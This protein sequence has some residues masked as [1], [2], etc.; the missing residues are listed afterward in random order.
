MAPSVHIQL[1]GTFFVSV[2][3]VTVTTLEV[4]RVQSLLAYL[5]LHRTAS[6]ARLH[7][8]SLF[9]PESPDAQALTNLRTVLH[10]IRQSLP[11]AEAFL[12]IDRHS[13]QWR[14]EP[15]ASWVFDVL[16][17]EHARVGANR[18]EQKHD[19]QGMR[20]ALEQA[21]ERY[22][23]D[24]LP[25]CYD[26]WILPERD[27]LRQ[28]FL[29]ALE[30]LIDL[31][32]QERDYAAAIT[33]AQRMLRHD[34]LR[35]ETYRQ[36]MRLYAVCGDRAAALRVY[37][38]C[39]SA[40]ERELSVE[41]GSATRSVYERLLQSQESAEPLVENAARGGA[42][43]LVGRKQEWVQLQ[44][45]WRRASAGETHL[46]VLAGEAGIGKTCL[47]E[48]LL[49]WVSRQGRSVAA[50]RCYATEGELAY[51][52]V[53]AW[54]RS[55]ALRAAIRNLPAIWLTEIAR[56]VPEV[57]AE[58][59]DLEWPTPLLES[60]QRQRLFE[61]L[62]RA[63]LAGRQ[64]LLLFLDDMHWGDQGTLEW[65]H[66]LLRFDTQAP[67]LLVGTLRP[68]E[69]TAE[70]PLRSALLALQR[71]KQVTEIHLN[72]LDAAE[73][74]MLAEHVARRP[75]DPGGVATLYQETE[76]N[77]LFVVEAVR[78]GF[79]EQRAGDENL[80]GHG[81]MLTPT[82]QAVLG[83]RLAQ[84]SPQAQEVAGLASVIGRAFTFAVLAQASQKEEEA[85]VRALDELWQRRIVREHGADA[86]DFSH[87][88]LREA[89]YAALSA[90]RQ[91]FLH[92]HVAQALE[93]LYTDALEQ[94]SGQ[95]AVHF[96]R[97]G[98]PV[99]A[100]TYY[101]Q[102]G[103]LAQQTYANVEAITAFRRALSLLEM[104]PLAT[105]RQAWRQE[106]AAQLQEH[107]GDLL[108]ISSEYSA[109]RDCYQAA[110]SQ[111]PASIEQARLQGKIGNTWE[112]QRNNEAALH[113]YELAEQLLG[114]Q[115]V[116]EASQ[117]WQQWIEIQRNRLQVYYWLA[118]T[119]KMRALI[120]QTQPIVAKHGVPSQRAA[121]FQCLY[122]LTMRQHRYL[123]P[124]E[125]LG[126]AE[127]EL[128][129]AQEGGN[130][131]EVGWARLDLG[132]AYLGRDQLDQAEEHLQAALQ[133]GEH[134]GHLMLQ[135]ICLTF[136]TLV[137]R[138]R[139]QAETVKTLLSRAEAV[140]NKTQNTEF[141]GIVQ[142]NLAWLAWREG[143]LA[144]T[145]THGNKALELW[146]QTSVV[147]PM[148]WAALWPLLG[149][150]LA[151]QQLLDACMQ[152]HRL[153]APDQYHLPDDLAALLTAAIQAWDG[154][155]SEM[156]AHHLQQALPLAQER[157][158][159]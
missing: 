131:V 83:A 82:V 20:Q 77:P 55:A 45:A 53:T 41:P 69:M 107:L 4:P 149:A 16:E 144:Q 40:L 74:T 21:V 102:A 19:R 13:I 62:A 56:C 86:Y 11:H 93:T 116:D 8:A 109:A 65:L 26:E 37:H 151:Q 7:L 75:L 154:E 78:A 100:I 70:H 27:R 133:V 139:G 130:V 50:A 111:C 10:H 153:L 134:T 28:T 99:R 89:T 2:D 6:Q 120:E 64:P 42:I 141:L 121:F 101:Q 135:G 129:A 15:G 88:Q 61:A 18:A 137:W 115:P 117:W 112:T 158:Y 132:G 145:K 155:Q 80:K 1:F 87:E 148:Q 34:S 36:L 119:E 114:E 31:L 108:A 126:Y 3:D 46:M 52:P 159:L 51:A 146:Q 143:K 136:L 25:G 84:L 5:L 14:P 54:L 47:A 63:V 152:A 58:R 79:L 38:T 72:P 97:A 60:W 35:E 124:D 96:E 66:Y 30:Q 76:G 157:G 90:T 9:W 85:L 23:G 95:L 128:A 123:V 150:A 140:A 147:Y 125:A 57:L 32:E 59:P 67:L 24:L 106:V 49:A 17:F 118:E 22:A 68:E 43:S 12:A 110:L 105:A 29:Q 44:A 122:L 33:M 91:R 81:P 113:A 142:A 94:V 138:S 98:M 156:A 127:S 39:A 73:T 71:N 48:E 92:R 104:A 103:E